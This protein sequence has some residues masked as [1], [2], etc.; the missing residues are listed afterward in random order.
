M[1]IST[2]WQC[3]PYGIC[4]DKNVYLYIYHCESSNLYEVVYGSHTFASQGV[5]PVLP[6]LRCPKHKV[7]PWNFE[8]KAVPPENFEPKLVDFWI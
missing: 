4:C 1:C 6:P 5:R 3:F 2:Y 8:T 7:P